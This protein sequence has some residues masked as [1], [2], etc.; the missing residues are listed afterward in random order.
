MLHTQAVANSSLLHSQWQFVVS[1]CWKQLFCEPRKHCIVCAR[2]ECV[3]V[4]KSCPT[5]CDPMD[6]SPPGSSVHEDS[7]PFPSPGD[8]ADP[9]IE[10]MSLRLLHWQADSFPLSH[11]GSPVEVSPNLWSFWPCPVWSHNGGLGADFP[12]CLVTWAQGALRTASQI[13][14]YIPCVNGNSNIQT[15]G[16]WVKMRPSV[17]ILVGGKAGC[18][19]EPLKSVTYRKPGLPWWLRG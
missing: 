16:Y 14:I 9:G 2:A 17:V 11:L 7:L 4:L 12:N 3:C 6:C 1:D 15:H 13:I 19:P 5:L 10:L 8:L 18:K